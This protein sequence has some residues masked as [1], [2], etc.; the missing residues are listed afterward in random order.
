VLACGAALALAAGA[1]A[2]LGE[3][4]YRARSFVVRVPPD[5]SGARGLDLAR[6]DK[7]LAHALELA[8]EADRGVGW[9]RAHSGAEL[10]SRMDLTFTV[11]TPERG[12][13]PRLA[14]AYARAFRSEIPRRAGLTTT[15]QGTRAAQPGLSPAGWALL[16]GAAGL[17]LGVAVAIVLDGRASRRRRKPA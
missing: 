5:F 9:L 10:T 12:L 7:V 2:L 4:D 11:E 3:R 1:V 8:G 16:G 13:S 14:T 17:W 15:A 6:S